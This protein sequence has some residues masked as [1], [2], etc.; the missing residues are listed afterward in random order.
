MLDFA[1]ERLTIRYVAPPPLLVKF[2]HSPAFTVRAAACR[3][4]ADRGGAEPHPSRKRHDEPQRHQYL[5]AA[6]RRAVLAALFPVAQGQRPPR[7]GLHDIR[8]YELRT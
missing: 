1:S 6:S 5:R 8:R 4:A 7:S 3:A 2:S